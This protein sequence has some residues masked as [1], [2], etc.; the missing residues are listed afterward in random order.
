MVYI[1]FEFLNVSGQ[2]SFDV[3]QINNQT[4][5]NTK[6]DLGFPQIYSPNSFL[7]RWTLGSLMTI[8]PI[9]AMDVLDTN[10]TVGLTV[11][12]PNGEYAVAID[13]TMLHNADPFKTYQLKVD[14]Y[15]V[16][17]GKYTAVD[18]NNNETSLPF[19]INV[20]DNIAPTI[21]VNF[22][23]VLQAK[24]GEKVMLPLVSATDNVDESLNVSV[25]VMTP[26]HR[27]T[28]LEDGTT[29]IVANYAGT[30]AIT[31]TVYDAAGNLAIQT[32]Y[33]AVTE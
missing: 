23:G 10:V 22:N 3:Y 15:G 14:Q 8:E 25:L 6:Y 7:G 29:H 4:M 32:I 18:G 24:V 31:Y 2:S 12:A 16:W 11:R 13:G 20:L 28:L 5:R 33:L 9:V 27:T 26:N 30:Y 1:S 21:M 17:S 19:T